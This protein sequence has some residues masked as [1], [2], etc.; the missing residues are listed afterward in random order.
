MRGYNK[1]NGWKE[2]KNKKTKNKPK[3][4]NIQVTGRK[5]HDT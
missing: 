1:S 5:C 3:K 4:P 2:E